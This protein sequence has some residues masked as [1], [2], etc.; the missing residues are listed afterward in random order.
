MDAVIYVVLSTVEKHVPYGELVGTTE[1][2]SITLYPR[3]RT[4]RGRY[5]RVQLYFGTG[6]ITHI[7][8]LK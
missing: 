7:K 6:H 8:R 4:N 1:C 5:N 3:C 2:T